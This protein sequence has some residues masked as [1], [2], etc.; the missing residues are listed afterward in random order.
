[1][2]TMTLGTASFQFDRAISWLSS[3]LERG[4]ISE[5]VFVQYGVSDVSPLMKYSL[6]T[7]ESVLEPQPL[8]ALLDASRLVISHAGQGSTRMLA[9][10][11]ARFVLLPRLKRY[12]EHVDDHQLWFVE[13][14]KEL[15][16]HHCLSLK[17]LEQ[18]VL[19][20]PPRFQKQLFSEPKLANQLLGFYPS[21]TLTSMST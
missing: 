12:A 10:R 20:P 21:K 15:G 11:G 19:Q 3:L 1:M 18:A 7:A 17:D 8:F 14:V 4:V 13:T 5:P 6:V 2:I 9:D 16:V